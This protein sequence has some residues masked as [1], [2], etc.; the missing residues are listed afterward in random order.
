M[1]I[2]I[3]LDSCNNTIDFRT[4][5]GLKPSLFM[6]YNFVTPSIFQHSSWG[7]LRFLMKIFCSLEIKGSENVENVKGNMIIA[8]NHI[9]ELDPMLIVSCLPFFSKHIPLYF[10][11]LLKKEYPN[12]WRKLLY[13]GDFF[14][15]MGAY[16]A[17]LGLKNYRESL[18]HHLKLISE[19]KNIVIFPMG[20]MHFE[21]GTGKAK[22]GAIF[23]AKEN[24]LP[25]IPVSIRGIERLTFTDVLLRKRKLTV[26][27]GKPIKL[28]DLLQEMCDITNLDERSIC[29]KAASIL[30]EK[31]SKLA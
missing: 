1:L 9:S 10:V 8:S 13:G 24:N 31:I 26:K 6:K 29:E 5:V 30:M 22:G 17:Y 23:L 19:G 27:F 18:K 14:R 7:P 2:V 12:G 3:I 25:I 4:S 15:L 20:K 11:S 21:D 16:P 28:E